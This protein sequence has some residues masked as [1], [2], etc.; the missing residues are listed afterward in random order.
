MKIVFINCLHY[1][2]ACTLSLQLF[3]K[4][5]ARRKLLRNLVNELGKTSAHTMRSYNMA[6]VVADEDLDLR[7]F[8]PDIERDSRALNCTRPK[9]R[10]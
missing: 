8:Q 7:S 1:H 5:F 3:M 4:K 2:S 10:S 6:D 9:K